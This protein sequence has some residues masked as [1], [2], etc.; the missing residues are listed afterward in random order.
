[1]S[2]AVEEGPRSRVP[3]V[4]RVFPRVAEAAKDGYDLGAVVW[5]HVSERRADGRGGI[6]QVGLVRSRSRARS[7]ERAGSSA[8]FAVMGAILS[9]RPP[10]CPGGEW[11]AYLEDNAA[12]A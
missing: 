6:R 5:G 4:G 1:M 12:L 9:D 2:G 7:R 3:V 11:T 10:C 8:G